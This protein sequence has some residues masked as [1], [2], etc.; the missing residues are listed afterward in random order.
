MDKCKFSDGIVIKPDGVHELDPCEY[1]EVER[2]AN[3]TV[4][5]RRCKKCDNIDIAWFR[6]EDTEKL[7]VE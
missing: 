6:Q 3:V 1:Q 7:E 4:S 5:I 2:Y